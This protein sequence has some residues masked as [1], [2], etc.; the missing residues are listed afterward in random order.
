MRDLVNRIHPVTA[1]APLAAAITDNTA[2]VTAII[3]RRGFE[4]LTFLIATG[5]LADADATFAVSI[6]HGDQANLSDAAAVPAEAILGGLAN[7]GF[8]FV[9]DAEPRKV[10]YAGDKRYVRMTITPSGNTGAAPLAVIAVLG[11]PAMAPTANPPI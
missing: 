1:L 4:S 10:G 2:Q 5:A 3:D 6:V 9:D 7:A 11:H 8:T